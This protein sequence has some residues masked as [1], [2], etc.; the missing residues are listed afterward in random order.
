MS[1]RSRPS[2]VEIVGIELPDPQ[3]LLLI[4]LIHQA[5][6]GVVPMGRIKRVI[7]QNVQPFS[8]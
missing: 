3:K 2:R 1:G 4:V 6:V 5:A 8:G 7:A